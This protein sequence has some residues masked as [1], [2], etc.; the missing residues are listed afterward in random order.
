VAEHDDLDAQITT[1]APSEA[2]KL[3]DSDE[4]KVQKREDHNPV[5]CLTADARKH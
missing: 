3:E 1:V 2:Q 5:S 4:G